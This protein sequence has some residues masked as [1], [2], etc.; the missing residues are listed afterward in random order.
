MIYSRF[1]EAPEAQ[2]IKEPAC[3]APDTR[4]VG[5][6]PGSG[7]SLKE[8]VATHTSVLAWEVPWTEEPRVLQSTGSQRV[9]HD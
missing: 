8:E 2:E 6:I 9:G 5:S 1:R 7:R 4:E 3:S